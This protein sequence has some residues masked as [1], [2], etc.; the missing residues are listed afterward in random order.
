[1]IG[2][3]DPFDA[4]PTWSDAG[5]RVEVIDHTGAQ[6]TGFLAITMKSNGASVVTQVE[7]GLD[8]VQKLVCLEEF[9]G[10]RFV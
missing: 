4:R 6:S 10:W 3:D 7:V 1:M 8:G 2:F 5:R 9:S